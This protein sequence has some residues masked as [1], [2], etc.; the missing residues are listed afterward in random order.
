MSYPRVAR[1]QF[2]TR[3]RKRTVN[4]PAGF[5]ARLMRR[6][7][8]CPEEFADC[9][10]NSYLAKE[11]GF[12]RVFVPPAPGDDGIAVGWPLYGAAVK[13]ELRRGSCAV[14][15]GRRTHTVQAELKTLGLHPAT[16]PRQTQPIGRRNA[17]RKVPWWRGIRACRAR[18]PSA[19]A[20]Q[21]AGQPVPSQ[22][23]RL[24]QQ[25]RQESGTF[26]AFRSGHRGRGD[27]RLL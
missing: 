8:V 12:A 4:T 18:P 22:H 1:Q 26:P 13:G 7:F 27:T 20:P 24:S 6:T 23:A 21:L 15:L 10:A 16:R 19:G 3:R 11:A 5:A 9:V 25:D 2:S 14:F 17:L